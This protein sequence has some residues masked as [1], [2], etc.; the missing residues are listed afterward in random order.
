L[1]DQAE[2]LVRS[3]LVRKQPQSQTY[4]QGESR[5]VRI[6][7]STLMW[8][9]FAL[10]IIALFAGTASSIR[11]IQAVSEIYAAAGSHPIGVALAAIA[12]TVAVEG[13]LF[14]LALA[15]EGDQ[16]KQRAKG[17]PRRVMSLKTVWQGIQVRI[18]LRDPLGYDEMAEGG[19]FG[20]LVFIAA[21]FAVIANMYLGFRPLLSQIGDV[22]LQMFFTT[23]WSAP[24]H[25]Q[26]T[27]LLD[28]AGTLFP[29]L[30][31]LA[32]GHLTARFAAE[33]AQESQGAKL[34]FERDM[35]VWRQAYANPLETDEGQL[36]LERLTEERI[37]AKAMKKARQQAPGTDFLVPTLNLNGAGSHSEME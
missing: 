18:G 33:I 22:S 27:F 4:L 24:A 31:A 29:P 13:A 19:G 12:F 9:R 17:T 25:L 8:S 6:T 14:V 5:A 2:K 3:S 16:L 34:A 35:E 37:Q 20:L 11:T 7:R 32:A 36:L 30:M 28:G 26:L 15:Q 21:A 23:L 1:Q 10:L